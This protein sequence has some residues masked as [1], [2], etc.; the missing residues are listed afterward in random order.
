MNIDFN[1]F[2]IIVGFI[3]ASICGIL[4]FILIKLWQQKAIKD[5]KL[6]FKN[7]NIIH[8][9]KPISILTFWVPFLTGGFYGSYAVPILYTDIYSIDNVTKDNITFFIIWAISANIVWF[10]MGLVVN[11]FT[12]KRIITKTPH[13]YT[14]LF[15][16]QYTN[17]EIQ[18]SDISSISL[19]R[20]NR[21][22]FTMKN[23]NKFLLGTYNVKTLY[24]KVIK[25]LSE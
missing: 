15:G 7:D 8:I 19:P 1:N 10:L 18:L 12:D 20:F 4:N 3:T 13:Q 17:R 23:G 11:V 24:N 9:I 2:C 22:E 25:Y 16:S 21:I 5:I 14:K 6:K